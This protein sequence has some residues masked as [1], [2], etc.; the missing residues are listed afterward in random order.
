LVS[1]NHDY[2]RFIT[3][4]E[5]QSVEE[6]AVIADGADAGLENAMTNV[7]TVAPGE[8][9]L[10]VFAAAAKDGAVK[11]LPK[12]GEKIGRNDPCWCG[13]GRKF[14]QCHGRP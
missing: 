9:E 13:S 5:A 8:S 11:A 6:E 14:K 3:H 2:V 1:I 12:E 7:D 10:P 4:V